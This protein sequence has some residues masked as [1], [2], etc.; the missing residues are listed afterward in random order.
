MQ[1]TIIV[2]LIMF[3]HLNYGCVRKADTCIISLF[4]CL[5]VFLRRKDLCDAKHAGRERSFVSKTSVLRQNIIPLGGG[6]G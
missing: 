6:A 5:L 4:G 1:S 3:Y 2:G